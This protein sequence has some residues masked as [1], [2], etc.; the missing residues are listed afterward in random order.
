M[1]CLTPA[2]HIRNA[3]TDEESSEENMTDTDDN[4]I[5]VQG[6]CL[7]VRRTK[8]ENT[9]LKVNISLLYTPKRRILLMLKVNISL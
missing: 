5:T 1:T 6:K 7:S 4:T 2:I 8:Q 9:I 3:E